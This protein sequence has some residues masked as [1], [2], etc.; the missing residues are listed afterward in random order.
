VRLITPLRPDE[1]IAA[2]EGRLDAALTQVLPKLGR[3]LP[4]V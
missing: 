2:A 1:P 3:F 4:D